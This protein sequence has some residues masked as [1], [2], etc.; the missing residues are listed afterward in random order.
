MVKNGQKGLKQ[1]KQSKMVKDGQK[2]EKTIKKGIL[3]TVK[4]C[5]QLSKWSK[6]VIARL[7]LSKTCQSR[8]KNGLKKNGF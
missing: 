6:T 4:N 2:W 7:K 5:Q 3:F 1:S 8:S